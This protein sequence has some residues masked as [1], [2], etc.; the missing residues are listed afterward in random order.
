VAPSPSKAN[1]LAS[2]EAIS[3]PRQLGEWLRAHIKSQDLNVA[4]L[5]SKIGVAPATLY[6]W[7]K[8]EHLP[9]GPDAD[10]PDKFYGLLALPEMCLPEAQRLALDDVRMRLTEGRERPRPLPLRGLPGD[11]RHFVGRADSMSALDGLLKSR[12]RPS[13][14]L[15]STVSGTGGVGKTALAVHWAHSAKAKRSFEHGYL[16]VNLQGFSAG[17]PLTT[18]MALNKLLLHLGVESSLIP[19][20]LDAMTALY[21]EQL[22]GRAILIVLDNVQDEPQVRPLLPSSP[23]CLALIT[24]R[25]RLA[26]LIASD[27]AT[28]LSLDRLR[29]Q[30]AITLLHKFLGVLATKTAHDDIA[31][32]ATECAYLPLALRIA[33]ATYLASYQ[34]TCLVDYVE[35]IRNNRLAMLQTSEHDDIMAVRAVMSWSC[36]HLTPPVARAFRLLGLHPGQDFDVYAAAALLQQDIDT[37]AGILRDL[38]AHSLLEET[39]DA[40]RPQ[41][42]GVNRYHMHDLLH[43]YVRELATADNVDG[44]GSESTIRLFDYYCRVAANAVDILDPGE[45]QYR[46]EIYAHVASVP[47]HT[48][49]DHATAWLDVERSNLVTIAR[50]AVEHGMPTYAKV[51]SSMLARHFNTRAYNADALA[52]HTHGLDAARLTHDRTNE[53]RALLNIATVHGRAGQYPLAASHLENALALSRQIGDQTNEARA[54]NNL[55]IVY[56]LLGRYDDEIGIFQDGLTLFRANYDLVGQSYVILNL[57]GAYERIGRYPEALDCLA[58]ALTVARQT[59]NHLNEGRANFNAGNIYERLGRYPEAL[60]HHERALAIARETGDRV[61]ECRAMN[62]LGTVCE[63]TGRYQEAFDYHEQALAIARDVGDPVAEGRALN[64]LGTAYEGTGHYAEALDHYEQALS[65]AKEIGYR[66]LEAGALNSMGEVLR[67]RGSSTKALECHRRALTISDVDR[68]RFE[69]ARAKKGI[70]D[71]LAIL[72]DEDDAATYLQQAVLLYAELGV[73]QAARRGWSP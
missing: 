54:L 59:A 12:S 73:P 5:A 21:Q 30:E 2:I 18:G 62:G 34:E 33:A 66:G 41:I 55:G 25:N 19:V 47:V 3:S 67:L 60:D 14:V 10:E 11:I 65:S 44:S 27:G 22:S 29:P 70:A 56:E 38:S 20:D 4:R 39:I 35:E 61:A 23:S 64:G 9:Q 50:H 51:L 26:G 24:S 40:A 69:Q 15:I 58:Q 32:L 68:D 36:K 63:D 13:T 31:R 16:Y 49:A 42:D 37:T 45:R 71:N 57:G 52:L 72:G 8:G 46:P 6:Y 53:A 7:L 17:P 43:D 48:S 1:P 28:S